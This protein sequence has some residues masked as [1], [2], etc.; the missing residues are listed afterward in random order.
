MVTFDVGVYVFE[1][2]PFTYQWQFNGTNLT[3][4]TNATLTVEAAPGIVGDYTVIVSSDLGSVTSGPAAL[5]LPNTGGQPDAEPLFPIWAMF[6]M[7][8][9]LGTFGMGFCPRRTTPAA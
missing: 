6:V 5:Q 7:V 8:L 2:S 9:G 3:G 1:S 4:A